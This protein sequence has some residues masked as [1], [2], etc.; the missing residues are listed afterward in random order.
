MAA[1]FVTETPNYFFE[2]NIFVL[3]GYL[4]L[5][6]GQGVSVVFKYTNK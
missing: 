1:Q 3:D 6:L 4:M 2:K 5:F